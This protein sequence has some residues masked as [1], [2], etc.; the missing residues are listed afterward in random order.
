MLAAAAAETAEVQQ[1]ADVV[2]AAEEPAS[3]EA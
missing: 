1:T 2:Y 3:Q